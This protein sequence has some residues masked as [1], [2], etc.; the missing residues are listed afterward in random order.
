MHCSYNSFKVF[1]KK[2]LRCLSSYSSASTSNQTLTGIGATNPGFST[3]QMLEI[4]VLSQY[5][6][7]SIKTVSC[8]AACNAQCM[9]HDV[10]HN[11]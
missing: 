1:L 8:I 7:S 4:I 5:Q 10:G 11:L 2:G 9:G 6:V 3:D